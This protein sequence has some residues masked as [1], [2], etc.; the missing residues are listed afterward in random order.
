MIDSAGMAKMCYNIPQ[1]QIEDLPFYKASDHNHKLWA[2]RPYRE[3]SI[4]RRI[5]RTR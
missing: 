5:R 2:Y 1:R 3:S 4:C